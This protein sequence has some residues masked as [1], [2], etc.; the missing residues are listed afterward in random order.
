TPTGVNSATSNKRPNT[1]FVG[2]AGCM[3]PIIEIPVTV[4]P[5]PDFELSSYK[6][7]SCEGG[8]S[9]LVTITT[10]LGGYDT[11]VWTPSTGVSGDATSGWTFTTPVEQEYTLTVSQ[12]S[13]ICDKMLTVVCLYGAES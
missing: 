2:T 8:V 11:F 3:S 1:V 9:E 13:G 12:A 5:K 10:N 6:V 7:T 4:S